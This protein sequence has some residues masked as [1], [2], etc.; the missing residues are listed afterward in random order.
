MLIYNIVRKGGFYSKV[1]YEH[2]LNFLLNPFSVS[3]WLD[4]LLP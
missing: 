4:R 1:D 2:S 3:G